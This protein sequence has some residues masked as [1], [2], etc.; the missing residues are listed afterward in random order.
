M[1]RNL[2]SQ[3]SNLSDTW[4]GLRVINQNSCSITCFRWP[5]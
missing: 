4:N 2:K 1:V 5:I 3:V